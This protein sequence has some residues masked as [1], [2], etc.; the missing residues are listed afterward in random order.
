VTSEV[1]ADEETEDADAQTTEAV[2][3][4]E[5]TGETTTPDAS[6]PTKL[7][8]RAST[9]EDLLDDP[10]F[11]V[12][13]LA[14]ILQGYAAARIYGGLPAG[15]WPMLRD[16]AQMEYVGW[17]VAEG[18]RL[19]VDVWQVKPPLSFEL[20]GVFALVTGGNVTLYH[21]LNLLATSGALVGGT[22]IAAAIVLEMTGD[23]LGAVVGGLGVFALPTY[24]WRTLIGFKPKYFVVFFGLLLI[25][26]VLRGRPLRAGIA[27]GI[28]VGFWQLA[29]VFPVVGLA[30]I[31]NR[32][33]RSGARRFVAGVAGVGAVV[34]LPVVWWGAVPAM[35][36]EAVLTPLLG[37]E[38]ATVGDRLRLGLRLLSG[39]GV[40]GVGETIPVALLGLAGYAGSLAGDRG[41][42]EWILVAVVGW[43]TL[44]L[45]LFD[46]DFYPDLFA[47]FA[48]VSIGA[49]L[50]VGRGSGDARRALAGAVLVVAVFSVLTLGG[51][52][53][54]QPG[55]PQTG[56]YDVSTDLT[57][58]QPLNDTER[59]YVFWNRVDTGSCRSFAGGT[60]AA[61]IETANLGSPGQP[62]WEVPCGRFSPVWDA[63]VGKYT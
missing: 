53:T 13:L 41:D 55:V 49:G 6:L 15:S 39:G 21:T 9:V 45:L 32:G 38:G 12:G 26:F 46:L 5:A 63:V 54:G 18:N 44:V 14:T 2:T 20:M 23:E 7:R 30:A 19:Y 24:Y 43:F 36:A 40:P 48:M 34:L 4:S 62:Y 52:G 42:R 16:S 28:A 31:L 1:K 25:W 60:Q 61:L 57:L 11:V 33:D 17:Y 59:Q 37:T 50:A 22:V 8:S 10:R 35:V 56:A 29:V 58:T 3:G 51:L 27:G 47:W